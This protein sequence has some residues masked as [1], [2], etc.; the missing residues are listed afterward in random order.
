[1]VHELNTTPGQLLPGVKIEP[2]YD[3]T[4]LINT[5]TETVR[6]NLFHGMALVGLVLIMF[7][8]NVRTALIV[9]INQ[10]QHYRIGSYGSLETY[11]KLLGKQNEAK[12]L[13][14]N[15]DE[16]KGGDAKFTKIAEETVNQEALQAS[17]QAA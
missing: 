16:S 4:R 17:M 3:R 13:T 7:L 14:E 1:M 12:G 5:T 2:Y 8:G 15:L 10:Q 6:E 11:A 9:A